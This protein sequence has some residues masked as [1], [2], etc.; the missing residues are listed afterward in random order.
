MGLETAVYEID[1]RSTLKALQTLNDGIANSESKLTGHNEKLSAA[2]AKV[3]NDL[4]KFSDKATQSQERFLK[5][6]ERQA[7]LAGRSGV[8]KLIADRDRLIKKYQQDEQAVNRVTAA[9]QK[10]IAAEKGG[11]ENGLKSFGRGIEQFVQS[12]VEAAQGAIT[13]L[14][15][16]I[17]PVGSVFAGTVIAATALG[18]ALF[19]IAKGF[20]ED[21][22]HLKIL[23]AQTGIS[24]GHL[25]KLQAMGKLVGVEIDGLARAGATMAVSL[26]QGGQKART[27]ESA[28]ARLK[29]ST[30]D[31]SGEQKEGGQ[32]IEETLEKLSQIPNKTEQIALANE[33][34]GKKGAKDVQVLVEKY[35]DLKH[36]VE[37]MGFGLEDPLHQAEEAATHLKQVG[38][39]WEALKRQIAT[40]I[41]GLI[42]ITAKAPD[43]LKSF[44][45]NGAKGAA[46]AL[47]GPVASGFLDF[48]SMMD[49]VEGLAQLNQRPKPPNF[50]ADADAQLAVQAG[51][52]QGTASIEQRYLDP[53]DKLKEKLKDLREDADALKKN[54]IV[55][56]AD[57]AEFARDLKGIQDLEHQ[58]KALTEAETEHKRI[59]ELIGSVQT[60]LNKKDS[61]LPES[62][63]LF[64][65]LAKAKGDNLTALLG[66]APAALQQEVAAKQKKYQE[67]FDK[68]AFNHG[69]GEEDPN[70]SNIKSGLKINEERVRELLKVAEGIRTASIAADRAEMSLRQTQELDQSKLA[71]IGADTPQARLRN[72]LEQLEIKKKFANEELAYDLQLAREKHLNDGQLENTIK[73]LKLKN[74]KE[75]YELENQQAVEF[76][77]EQ[78]RQLDEIKKTAE[79]LYHTLFTN[80][81]AFNKQLTTTVRDAALKPIESG[82]ASVTASFLQPVVFGKNDGSVA[83]KPLFVQVVGTGTTPGVSSSGGGGWISSPFHPASGG[84]GFFP[85]AVEPTGGSGGG[86]ATESAG[87]PSG[88]SLPSSGAFGGILRGLGGKGF[89]LSNFK[90]LNW[91][92]FTHAGDFTGVG[93]AKVSGSGRIT[94]VDGLAGTALVAGGS[95]LAEAGL[96]GNS[97]GTGLGIFESGLGGAALGMKF[98][99]PIGAAIGAAAGT[100]AGIGEKLA[101]VESPINEAKR[102]VKQRYNVT[103]D[104]QFAQKVVQVAQQKY[105]G[106][107]SLAV[108]DPEIRNGLMVY[109]SGTGQKVPLS[110]TMP[111][112]GGLVESG[113]QLQQQA[114]YM[115]G[116]AYTYASNLPTYGGQPSTQ[117][118]TPTSISLH[119]DGQGAGA[120]MAG[121]VVTPDF[122]QQQTSQAN[123][124][125]IGRVQNSATLN[126]PLLLV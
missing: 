11:D 115:F 49:S 113:G 12:P 28:L 3:S 14:L 77:N 1:T 7:E 88:M 103:I 121:Q 96:L 22:E 9:Y 10:L 20:A 34:L 55:A 18:T 118:P 62:T 78:K 66:A 63:R 24:V 69:K 79:G 102:L 15:E 56:I 67:E 54:G 37:A 50:A 48:N 109:A 27:M 82:L 64:D 31:L 98:G 80:P 16:K 119:I 60:G 91:G 123:Q 19:S 73:D 111:H 99:G 57:R 74:A 17:G 72:S 71:G 41:E 90:G 30:V 120:F 25:D 95:S 38:L 59:L 114:S 43:W 4:I 21:A 44:L 5:S 97:R 46:V 112:A 125:S 39:E 61:Q 93:G 89:N 104:T 8:D 70:A 106:K 23:S 32:L 87:I 116:Q 45:A 101:G 65:E 53:I 52:R 83:S 58:I 76:A 105:G 92:G 42:N 51:L 117:L 68:L 75:V 122:V 33:I 35:G 29:I 13:G 6:L 94:G 84:G 107:V 126:Q 81:K 85:S 110:S 108:I 47:G 100:L 40:P 26:D 86:F 2:F 124:Y 36:A